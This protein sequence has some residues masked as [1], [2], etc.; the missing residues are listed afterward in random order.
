MGLS[1]HTPEMDTEQPR[2]NVVFV[3]H[4]DHGKSTT[5]GRLCYD[6]GTLSPSKMAEVERISKE[7]GRPVE[8]AFVMDNLEEERTGGLTIDT[9][10]VFFNSP[11][12]Q[13]VIIDAPGH[14]EFLK[15][16]MTGASQAEAALLVIDAEEGVREQSRRHAFVLSM[17][18]VKE[19]VVLINKMDAVDWDEKRFESVKEEMLQFMK[20]IGIEPNEVIPISAMQG[21]NIVTM[22]SNMTWYNGPTVLDALD[23]LEKPLPLASRALRLPVQGVYDVDEKQIVAGR[24][25]AGVLKQGDNVRIMPSGRDA[26]I[27]TVEEFGAEGSE[28]TAGESIG[29]TLETDTPIQRGETISDPN[30]LPQTAQKLKC[31]IFWMSDRPLHKDDDLILRCTTQERKCHVDTIFERINSST[32]ELIEEDASTL[33]NMEVGELLLEVNSPVAVEPFTE[34]PELG[35]FV[36]ERNHDV[37]AGGTISSVES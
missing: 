17:M 12:R 25:E 15:N 13:Y 29:L 26:T 1:E 36:L 22:S 37:V 10:Q 24:V 8:F 35:R 28:A 19:N 6:T 5:I 16:M 32:L 18:N 34:L 14:R 3:G 9:A 21:D 20:E 27:K 7:L 11:Q 33:N 23:A 30:S 4:V 2:M 31:S